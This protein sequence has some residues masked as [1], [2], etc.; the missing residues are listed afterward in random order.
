MQQF[1][2][3]SEQNAVCVTLVITLLF[4]I[5]VGAAIKGVTQQV[6]SLVSCIRGGSRTRFKPDDIRYMGGE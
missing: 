1:I 3:N 2:E 4:D 5:T 6:S